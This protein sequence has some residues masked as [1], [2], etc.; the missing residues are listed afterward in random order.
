MHPDILKLLIVLSPFY[1]IM[2]TYQPPDFDVFLIPWVDHIRLH[3][4]IGAFSEPF[5]NYSPPYLYLLALFS[6]LNVS[7]FT[8]IKLLALACLG[9]LAFAVI[10]LVKAIGGDDPVLAGTFLLCLPTSVA[11]GPLL[12]QCDS[13]W[14]GAC[15]LS[16]AAAVERR[17][18]PMAVWAGIAFA[19]KAQAAF[20]APLILLLVVRERKWSA[21][22]IPPLIYLAAVIPAWIAGW[23]ILDLL[24]IYFDQASAEFRGN[25]PN[26]WAIPTYMGWRSDL[27]A[28]AL[29]VIALVTFWLRPPKDVLVA[30]LLCALI[31]A[32]LLPKMHE[33]YF[34]LAEALA[35]VLAYHRREKWSIAICVLLQIG[36]VLSLF[37]YL[38]PAPEYNAIGSAFVA[39]ALVLAIME[40]RRDLANNPR[41]QQP[42]DRL[43]RYPI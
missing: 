1:G 16:L 18:I 40:W 29:A 6:M 41:C 42:Q 43:A 10:R 21:L 4:P 33:R 20:I 12:A 5:G 2:A 36:S 15:L 17:T 23:P 14:V 32:F 34:F 28:Y 30:G 26:L 13:L 38:R 39:L 37:A 19:F 24:T 27:L 7:A 11:N 35:F 25:A 9:W 3:G 22:A 8:A 31:F